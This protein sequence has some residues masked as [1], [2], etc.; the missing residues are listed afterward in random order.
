MKRKFV[1]LAATVALA[2]ALGVAAPASAA[3]VDPQGPP[4][5]TGVR[6]SGE[7]TRYFIRRP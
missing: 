3:P 4:A 2:A 5:Q 6:P 7:G 1:S